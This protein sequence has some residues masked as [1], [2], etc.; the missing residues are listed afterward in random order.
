MRHEVRELYC[1][2]WCILQAAT[3]YIVR[4]SFGTA[5][6]ASIVFV[7][8]TIIGLLSSR[9][10]LYNLINNEFVNAYETSEDS[11]V[12]ILLQ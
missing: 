3:E 2:Y 1:I 8:T 7:Y 12:W 11:N 6:I 9:R 5:L 10:Y 4:V